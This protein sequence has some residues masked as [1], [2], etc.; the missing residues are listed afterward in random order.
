MMQ[1]DGK[2]RVIE[3]AE[4]IED[5]G[6]GD[7]EIPGDQVRIKF[8]K[9]VKEFA[10]VSPGGSTNVSTMKYRDQFMH[11]I[12][13]G[14]YHLEINLNDLTA[15]SEGEILSHVLRLR[16][17]S[18]V[19]LAEKALQELY[20]EL[21]KREGDDLPAVAPNIQLQLSADIDLEGSFGTMK[22]MMIRDIN[23]TQ[24]EKLILVQ[25]IVSAV[26]S[27]R[28]KARKIVLRCQRCENTKTVTV[29]PGFCAAHIP[30]ACDGNE[31]RAANEKCPPNP[32]QVIDSLCEYV[33]EQMLKLQELPEDV[34]VGE[35]P[36]SYDVCVQ[37]YSV[38]LCTPGTRLTAIGI[39][40]ATEHSAG[41]KT[42]S[43]KQKGTN[44][45]KY[46]YIQVLG[47]KAASGNN[48]TGAS[49]QLTQD[50]KERFKAL[51]KS[52]DI[53]EQI[54]R[55]IAPAI[56]ASDKDVID[57]VKRAV[58]CML[59]SGSRK[60]LPDGTRMRGDINVL[61]LGDPGTAKSQFLKFSEKA[62][63]ISVYTSGKGSSA[64][65]LTA[66]IK[67]D[68][69]GFSLEGGAMVLADGGIVCIDEFDKMD[70]K[71]RV[72]IHEAMEQQTISIAKAGITT[73]LN[74]RCSVLA[75]ANPRFG[76]YDD[77]TNTAD[78]MDFE[79]TILSR[80]DMIFLVKDVR[81]QE[82]DFN[83]AKHLAG[84]HSGEV[85]E[86]SEGP[87]PIPELRKYT[88]YCRSNC[89]PRLG[90]EAAE[91]LKNHYVSI[92]KAMKQERSTIPITVRQLEAIV[93]MSESLAK[94]ELRDEVHVG[95]VEEALRL[96]TVST[97][98]SANKDRGIGVDTLGEQERDE[99]QKAEAQVMKLMAKGGRKSKIELHKMLVSTTGIEE[100]VATKAI[101]IMTMRGELI[102]K[103]GGALQ[104]RG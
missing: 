14:F 15:H 51:A 23:S 68:R 47:V 60:Q 58:A 79:S 1:E 100:R 52:G 98:D 35:M 24:V 28:H 84:L 11:N 97:L 29:N 42:T 72:A 75:A 7:Y 36:R 69:S 22:P 54:F 30:S 66:A 55:S 12:G 19:P 9:F 13:S 103:H 90:K 43:A 16:P 18:F 48:L 40:C 25:G 57:D 93:R 82:R 33:D 101:H 81:D 5:I 17:A 96:F 41:E 49:L 104:R 21:V 94:M 61:L 70:V 8:K 2:I 95:H 91:V 102:E 39:Y 78:Q 56:R 99:L 26:K 63:P 34:P 67:S 38:D 32:F 86:Q 87:L 4:V 45:V 50:E 71:D 37:Q 64:A 31:N 65:G 85:T 92:R 77:L 10:Y 62:A 73:M 83:L 89:Q 59:F 3:G 88:S 46:S 44:T 74:T 27:V 80:F 20:Y 53:R 76:T 6:D